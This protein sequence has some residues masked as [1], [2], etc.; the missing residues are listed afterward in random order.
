METIKTR[1][2]RI[3]DLH[4][5]CG[6]EYVYTKTGRV[7]AGDGTL[8]MASLF[9]PK[10]GLSMRAPLGAQEWLKKHWRDVVMTGNG[11]VSELEHEKTRRRN[12]NMYCQVLMDYFLTAEERKGITEFFSG[13]P[14]YSAVEAEAEFRNKREEDE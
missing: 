5:A 13:M 3:D 1:A 7:V 8:L 9:C 2:T 10:C 14:G 11:L 4:C 6:C 12:L